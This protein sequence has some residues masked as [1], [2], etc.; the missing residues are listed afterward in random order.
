MLS[1]EEGP[2]TQDREDLQEPTVRDEVDGDQQ[3]AVEQAE[4]SLEEMLASP[5]CLMGTSCCHIPQDTGRLVT[6]Y[7]GRA[8]AHHRRDT[9]D[10]T[11]N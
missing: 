11:A 4:E 1:G 10:Y 8:R 6:N 7:K 3:G 9:D 2:P 5:H